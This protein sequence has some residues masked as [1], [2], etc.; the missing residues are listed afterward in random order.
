MVSFACRVLESLPHVHH[1]QP[2]PLTFAGSQPFI[3]HIQALFRA[4]LPSKPNGT[5]PDQVADHDAVR[6]PLADGDLVDSKN[7]RRRR[8]HS[9]QLFLHVLLVQLLDR[10]PIQV[11]LAGDILEG[12]PPAPSPN[13]EG[14]A[15]G[16]KRIVG[17]PGQLLLLH[18]AAVV[19][20][21]PPEFDL[22]INPRIAAGKIPNA[23]HFVIVEAPGPSTTDPTKSFFPWRKRPMTRALG[24]PKMPCTAVLG[25]KPGKRYAS[26]S[27]REVRIGESCHVFSQ[28]KPP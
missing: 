11:Q 2:N 19:A 23:A 15:L 7:L 9:P 5:A 21:H 17:Y 27:W 12:C 22:Q 16:V 10:S 13:E 3:E 24:S 25:R 4:I 26:A 6:M 1:Y 20:E 28:Q 18:V 8:P 14:K